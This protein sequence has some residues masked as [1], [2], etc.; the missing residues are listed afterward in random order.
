MH[1]VNGLKIGGYD[2]THLSACR[3]YLARSAIK[4]RARNMPLRT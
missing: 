1:G 4:R 3:L 2:N